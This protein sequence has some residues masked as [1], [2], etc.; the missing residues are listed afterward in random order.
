MTLQA[1]INS[2]PISV[3]IDGTPVTV[4]DQL[5]L[6]GDGIEDLFGRA[7]GILGADWGPFS[8]IFQ[9]FL[10]AVAVTFFVVA[11]TYSGT[12]IGFLFGMVRKIYTAIMDFIPS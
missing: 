10:V 11:L 12:I 5:D 8:P 9:A 7:K 2:T 3:E 1:I 6:A 4:S